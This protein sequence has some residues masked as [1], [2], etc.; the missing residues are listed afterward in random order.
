M[1]KLKLICPKCLTARI[2]RGDDFESVV[3]CECGYSN[4]A[5]YFWHTIYPVYTQAK[6]ANEVAVYS[7]GAHYPNDAL[8]LDEKDFIDYFL[9]KAKG[10]IHGGSYDVWIYQEKY[11]LLDPPL[12]LTEALLKIYPYDPKTTQDYAFLL[13]ETSRFAKYLEGKHLPE[14]EK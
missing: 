3:N 14:S 1:I 2:W 5:W 11:Q 4:E 6:G 9:G 13:E 10:A 8:S 12:V 7:R